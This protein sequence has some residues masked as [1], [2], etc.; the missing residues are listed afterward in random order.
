[1]VF[2][3]TIYFEYD[4]YDAPIRSFILCK[5]DIKNIPFQRSQSETLA[6][7]QAQANNETQVYISY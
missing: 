7:I 2:M 1:M 6:N 5:K 4:I 3:I